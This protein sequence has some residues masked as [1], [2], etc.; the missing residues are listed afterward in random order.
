M[1]DVTS[2]PEHSDDQHREDPSKSGNRHRLLVRGRRL[3]AISVI[4]D[5]IEGGVATT[6]AVLSGSTTLLGFGV[7]SVIEV[8][9]AGT[10]YWRLRSEERGQ[11]PA[12]SVERRALRIVS[13]AFFALAL[14][15]AYE[16]IGGLVEGKGP[17]SSAVGLAM[18]VIS[19]VAMPF[20]AIAKRRTGRDLDSDALIAD[21]RETIASTY[22]AFT[23][24][25][26]LGLNELFGW[27]WADSV[28]ALAMLPYLGWAGVNAWNDSNGR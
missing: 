14:Y 25:G 23:V 2:D 21:S 12:S 15:V 8:T 3:E 28:A 20:L 13:V 17:E 1:G 10:L 18:A 26:G 27:W 24:L 5:V 6:A 22:L 11:A 4:Y 7:E 16:A 9:A 19:I